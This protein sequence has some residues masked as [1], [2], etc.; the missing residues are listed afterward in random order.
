MKRV[1]SAFQG[2]DT[3]IHVFGTTEY[4]KLVEV[5]AY[6]CD[7]TT[8]R[9]AGIPCHLRWWNPASPALDKTEKIYFGPFAKERADLTP[10]FNKYRHLEQLKVYLQEE[11]GF[12]LHHLLGPHRVQNLQIANIHYFVQ[13]EKL[14]TEEHRRRNSTY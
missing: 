4:A 5:P 9:M 11:L 3:K 14:I 8:W 2:Q 13:L 6:S 1:F 12:E 7:S 10:Y